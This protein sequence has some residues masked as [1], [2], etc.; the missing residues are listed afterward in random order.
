MRKPSICG[1]SSSTA[2]KRHAKT[3]QDESPLPSTTSSL[4]HHASS[5]SIPKI[6]LDL[7]AHLILPFV[8][9][10]ATWNSVYCASKD[11]CLA[12]KKMTPPWP[13][14]AFN[15]F[16]NGAVSHIAFPPFGFFFRVAFSPLGSHLA[17]CRNSD[18][19][20]VRVWDRWGK[21][22]ILVGHTGE[23]CCLE[24]SSDGEYLAS[25]SEIGSIQLWRT[26]SFHAASS[27]ILGERSTR[28]LE[29]T[30]TVLSGGRQTRIMTLSF[31]RTDSNLLAS[32]ASSGEVKVWN[33]KE[34]ACIHAFNPDCGIVCSLFFAGGADISCTVV[35]CNGYI[36]RLWRAE[37]SSDFASETI[38]EGVRD[39]SVLSPSG[40]FLANSM[41]TSTVNA[42]TLSL[43]ELETMTKTQSVTIPDFM[44]SC[45]AL[46]LDSKQL[47]VGDYTGKIRLFQTD[48][49]FSSQRDIIRSSKICDRLSSVAFDPTGRVLAYGCRD[50]TLEL[51]T[52]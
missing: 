12:A 8:A 49:F 11:L 2:S 34:Q 1:E 15:N 21:E 32:G 48:D 14:K 31:S 39:R 50:G 44:A 4:A 52:L 42:S 35:A 6:P 5:T 25:G 43:Y 27:Q 13:N 23:T 40:S 18:Q 30:D 36:I 51:R 33:V 28:R 47:V 24:Y 17:F 38:G 41:A 10:R 37:G 7:I 26:E 19:H 16:E 22:T 3:S 45:F 20:V 29:H 9:D 46:S